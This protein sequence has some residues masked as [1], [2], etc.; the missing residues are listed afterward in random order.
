MSERE[1]RNSRI[2]VIV[3]AGPREARII[4]RVG[5]GRRR[6]YDLLSPVCTFSKQNIITKYVRRL[7]LNCR[8]TG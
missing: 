7:H 3:G 2:I 1:G 4:V 8:I 6:S 5:G